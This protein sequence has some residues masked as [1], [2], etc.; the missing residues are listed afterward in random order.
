MERIRRIAL[1]PCWDAPEVGVAYE[2]DCCEIFGDSVTVRYVP[3]NRGYWLLEYVY[4]PDRGRS[5]TLYGR[6]AREMV[7]E[8]F[9]I[10]I[11]G[12]ARS[13][14]HAVMILTRFVNA[15]REANPDAEYVDHCASRPVYRRV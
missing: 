4:A 9:G 7:R 1:A 5:V 6:A 2:P 3:T 14:K 11:P 12:S 15:I 10:D 8:R 13:R